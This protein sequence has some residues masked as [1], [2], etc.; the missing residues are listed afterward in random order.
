M[1]KLETRPQCQWHVTRL[2]L[3]YTLPTYELHA[4]G[5]PI[6]CLH[7]FIAEFRPFAS[8]TPVI[9]TICSRRVL[10]VVCLS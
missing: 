1:T 4:D 10:P 9:V 8:L 2:L 3:C 7:N 6:P 5:F